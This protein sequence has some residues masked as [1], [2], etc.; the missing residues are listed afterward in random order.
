MASNTTETTVATDGPSVQ[1]ASIT[2]RRRDSW[3]QLPTPSDMSHPAAS[4]AHTVLLHG[5]DHEGLVSRT[6][7]L[8]EGESG[9]VDDKDNFMN[10]NASKQIEKMITPYLAHHIPQQYNPLGGTPDSAPSVNANTK[11]CYRHRPDLLCRRQ[12]D[13]PTM[14]SLQEVSRLVYLANTY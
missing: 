2:R 14:E 3:R 1:A 10:K 11:Y 5:H 4:D 7:H 8:A 9:D 13:E 6:R 12:A